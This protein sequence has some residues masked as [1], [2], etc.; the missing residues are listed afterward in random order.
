MRVLLVNY[1]YPDTT[2]NC[3]GGGRVTKT[4]AQGLRDRGHRVR[5]VTDNAGAVESWDLR[6]PHDAGHYTTFPFRAY[7]I[8]DECVAWADIVNGHFSVPSG[9]LLPHL[10]DRHDTPLVTSVMGADVY[11]PTRFNGIRPLIDVVNKRV[12]RASDATIAPSTDMANRVRSKYRLDCAR[13]SYGVDVDSWQWRDRDLHDP[14]RV[15]T[16]GR[17]VERKNWDQAARA[18]HLAGGGDW[19]WRI[20][21]QGPE[22]GRLERKFGNIA[23]IRGYVPDL[24]AE[25]EWADLFFLPSKHEAFGMV[26]LEA[27][28]SGLPV[29]TSSVGGQT[30]IVDTSV[31]AT[32]PPD[33]QQA[34]ADALRRVVHQYNWHQGNTEDYVAENFA[35]AQMV[36]AYAETYQEVTA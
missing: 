30:D 4:L 11:D 35:Q 33:D 36:D 3:G 34:L 29:V 2:E 15:L 14:P 8:L 23:T 1:E 19:D 6:G 31:G 26:F 28:A 24:Q 27:L 7:P 21:G 9:L 22:R 25:L 12:L 32:A 18:M 10:C 20:V 13:I 17:L 16:I 5:V